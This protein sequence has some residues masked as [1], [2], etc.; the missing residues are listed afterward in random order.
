MDRRHTLKLLTIGL[1]LVVAIVGGKIAIAGSFKESKKALCKADVEKKA[2]EDVRDILRTVEEETGKPIPAPEKERYI[3]E[4][5][6]RQVKMVARYY[7][8]DD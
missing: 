8:F 4:Y 1:A 6:T 3:Q 5:V 2:K 7:R